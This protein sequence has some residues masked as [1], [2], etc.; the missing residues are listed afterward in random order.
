MSQIAGRAPTKQISLS[1]RNLFAW[2]LTL[3]N[4][5]KGLFPDAILHTS[6]YTGERM[7]VVG[8]WDVQ[9]QYQQQSKT[10]R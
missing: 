6:T 3:E 7:A 5:Q 2:K 1:T 8:E 9:V 10:S 4:Q